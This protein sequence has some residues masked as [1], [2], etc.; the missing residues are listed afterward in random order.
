MKTTVND[1]V[2]DH[3]RETNQLQISLLFG[4]RHNNPADHWNSSNPIA[5][6]GFSHRFSAPIQLRSTYRGS[7]GI[8]FKSTRFLTALIHIKPDTSVSCNRLSLGSTTL[9]IKKKREKEGKRKKRQ[10][11]LS[12]SK[13]GGRKRREKMTCTLACSERTYA[14]AR[15]DR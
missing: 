1:L 10:L 4:I 13:E 7:Y 3:I 5:T 8:R 11:T 14:G 2:Y 15:L 6:F 9:S 12:L